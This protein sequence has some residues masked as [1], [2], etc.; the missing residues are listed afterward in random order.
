MVYKKNIYFFITCMGM[1]AYGQ[2]QAPVQTQSKTPESPASVATAPNPP[3]SAQ[4]RTVP[5]VQTVQPAKGPYAWGAQNQSG[6]WIVKERITETSPNELIY[7][8]YKQ[9]TGNI[10]YIAEAQALHNRKKGLQQVLA[11][12]DDAGKIEL[13]KAYQTRYGKSLS[14]PIILP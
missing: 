14:D 9:M 3:A 7:P 2:Q 13:A 5:Q 11:Q 8:Q 12:L 1:V 10:N 4:R 6:K